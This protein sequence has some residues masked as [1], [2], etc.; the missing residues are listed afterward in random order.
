MALLRLTAAS[1]LSVPTVPPT[2]PTDAGQRPSAASARNRTQDTEIFDAIQAH[3]PD[4]QRRVYEEYLPLVRGLVL[5]SLGPKLDFEDLIADTFVAFFENATNIRSAEGL[6]SYMVSIVMNVVRRELRSR[7]RRHL[8]FL[9]DESQKQAEGVASVDDPRAKAALVQLSQ[10]LND[11]DTEDRLTFALCVLEGLKLEEA[12]K[13][14][15]VSVSSVKRRLRRATERVERKVQQNPLLA[16]YVQD[17]GAR[18][19]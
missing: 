17:R 13:S 12:A 1:R 10:I 9:G 2:P 11:L 16:D 14:L 6:R 18:K 5:R 4:W 3:S 15:G 7:R 19:R 8:F